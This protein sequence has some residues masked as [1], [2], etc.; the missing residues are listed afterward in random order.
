MK[1]NL[2]KILLIAALV[3]VSSNVAAVEPRPNTKDAPTSIPATIQGI[4]YI[5]GLNEIDTNK[6]E[7]KNRNK[8][9]GWLE[10]GNNDVSFRRT[11]MKQ[12]GSK[13]VED[14]DIVRF[15]YHDITEIY[16]GNDAINRAT[17]KL[18]SGLDNVY[19]DTRAQ[20]V[21]LPEFM[22]HRS[23]A[24]IIIFFK[25]D[26]STVSLVLRGSPNTLAAAYIL[27]TKK[28]GLKTA[29]LKDYP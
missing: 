22:R 27:I 28:T 5:T 7:E 2:K 11:R 14:I 9:R 25:R 15:R 4:F 8:Y 21:P 29:P 19:S 20:Y 18:P 1:I 6:Y 26:G 13:G 10:L 3:I 12:D 16:Y 24:P 23:L 17:S